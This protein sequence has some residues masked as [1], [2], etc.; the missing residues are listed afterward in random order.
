MPRPA[1]VRWHAHAAAWRADVGPIGKAG[2]RSPVYWKFPP[3]AA[4][5][6]QAA[7]ALAAYLADRG[8]AEAEA[9]RAAT[10]PKVWEVVEDYLEHSQATVAART[11]AGHAERLA[12][13]EATAP[14]AVADVREVPRDVRP[15]HT[16]TAKD[17][18]RVIRHWEKA[19]YSPRY[20][21]NL[22]GS[23][24]ACWAW[25]ASAAAE[26]KPGQPERLIP[27][28][29]FR[30]VKGPKLPRA[31]ERYVAPDQAERLLGW[32]DARA[33]E[34]P[35]V[36]GA[37]ERL[38]ALLFRVLYETGARPSELCRATWEGFLPDPGVIVLDAHKTADATGRPRVVPL[39]AELVRRL[40]AARDRPGRHPTAIFTHRR[41][42]VRPGDGPDG[43]TAGA[44]WA[45]GPLG[46]RF[47]KLRLQAEAEGLDVNVRDGLGRVVRKNPGCTLYDFRRSFA[48]DG[49]AA[50][51]ADRTA[52]VL[53]HSVT[54]TERT[55]SADLARGLVEAAEAVAARRRGTGG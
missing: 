55:Y 22:L 30:E 17:L 20:I 1:S 16:L 36:G 2:R 52:A 19:G 5:K 35:G 27:A 34:A 11:F 51:G 43:A 39:T 6:A 37:H 26:R 33:A 47:R 29:P 32:I 50:G 24:K 31:P 54:M 10:A 53:G 42:E 48:T 4:G 41:A 9:E 46:Q 23:V 8:Q 12:T 3:T 40:V 25:A 15:A 7:Q 28:D 38:T 49:T 44:P 14:G 45:V 13:W 21:A 18:R